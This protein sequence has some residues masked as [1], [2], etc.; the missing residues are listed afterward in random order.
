V[1]VSEFLVPAGSAVRV[2]QEAAESSGEEYATQRS[3]CP[4]EQETVLR[5][6]PLSQNM[7]EGKPS[8]WVTHGLCQIIYILHIV[9]TGYMV[10][11]KIIIIN[12]NEFHLWDYLSAEESGERYSRSG[13]LWEWSNII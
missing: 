13:G 2:V 7:E 10:A 1:T 11:I 4:L 12:L 9:S 8:T 3:S 6:I 5:Q